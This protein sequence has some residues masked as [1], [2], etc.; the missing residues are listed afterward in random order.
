M[1]RPVYMVALIAY[2]AFIFAASVLRKPD[3]IPDIDR[4]DKL[5]HFIAY[6]VLG[7]LLAMYMR[8]R[9]SK[10]GTG[11]NDDGGRRRVMAVSLAVTFFFGAFVELVQYFTTYRSAEAL[12]AVANGAGGLFGAFVFERFLS[13]GKIPGPGGGE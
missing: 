13:P 6:A 5:Y 7:F 11:R 12:D 10:G 9:G 1:K 2:M 8:A 4:I 3:S